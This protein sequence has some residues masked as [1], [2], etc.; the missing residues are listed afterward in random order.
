MVEIISLKATKV[1]FDKPLLSNEAD[2]D[3][4]LRS[5]REALLEA[6]RTGKRIQI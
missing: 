3:K 2:V 4:Y 5:M 1:P 6:I